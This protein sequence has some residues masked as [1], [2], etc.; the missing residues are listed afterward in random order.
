MSKKNKQEEFRGEDE[1]IDTIKV[2]GEDTASMEQK[3]LLRNSQN[4]TKMSSWKL[5]L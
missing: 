5:Q 3:A 2:K 4:K 1:I